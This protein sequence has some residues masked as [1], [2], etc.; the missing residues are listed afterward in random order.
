LEVILHIIKGVQK[1][2]IVK[3]D[4]NGVLEP[5]YFTTAGP[6]SADQFSFALFQGLVS[7]IIPSKF[8]GYY[9]GGNFLK[10]DGQASQPLIKI[11]GLNGGIPV[12]I[13]ET[14][15]RAEPRSEVS[16][17]PN[18]SNGMVA[19]E[20]E[21][22]IKTIE[23]FDLR[24]SRLVKGFKEYNFNWS[25]SVFSDASIQSKQ[26]LNHSATEKMYRDAR[27]KS[28]DLTNLDNGIYFLKVVLKN[29]VVLTKK[30]I[31]Q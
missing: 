25:S 31:K 20:S 8:G 15:L 24:G 18:P 10:W 11:T 4:S 3:L 16:V 19:I 5:Q 12:G 23:V 26:S 7:A 30:I 17:Y 21:A 27:L 6:D 1:K 22:E 14:G 29:G 13:D 9:V 2:S 28:L